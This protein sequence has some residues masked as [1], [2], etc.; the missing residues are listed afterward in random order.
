VFLLMGLDY[1]SLRVVSRGSGKIL[2]WLVSTADS[3]RTLTARDE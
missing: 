1:S 3:Q 2:S